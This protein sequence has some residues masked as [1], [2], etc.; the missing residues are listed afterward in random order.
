MVPIDFFHTLCVSTLVGTSGLSEENV[1]FSKIFRGQTWECF[2]IGK[3]SGKLIGV[4]MKI[5]LSELTSIRLFQN[6]EVTE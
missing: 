1:K 3:V 2:S 4:D 6:I 5:Q